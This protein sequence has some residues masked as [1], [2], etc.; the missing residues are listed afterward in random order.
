[1]GT[2]RALSSTGRPPQTSACGCSWTSEHSNCCVTCGDLATPQRTVTRLV[3]GNV[4]RHVTIRVWRSATGHHA[5][6]LFQETLEAVATGPEP[7]SR[8]AGGG[9]GSL[10]WPWAHLAHRADLHPLV[11][12]QVA[13]TAIVLHHRRHGPNLV[14]SQA[15]DNEPITAQR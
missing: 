1:M 10:R 6:T 7:W 12:M 14:I 5:L 13:E 15:L 11:L 2:G 9:V 3:P 4:G 8:V